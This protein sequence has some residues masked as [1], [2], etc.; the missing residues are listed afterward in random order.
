MQI[1]NLQ[2]GCSYIR[3]AKLLDYSIKMTSFFFHP[4]EDGEN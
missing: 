1:P 4:P 2:A 3:R